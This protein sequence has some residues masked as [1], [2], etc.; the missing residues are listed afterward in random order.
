MEHVTR[1]YLDV[2]GAGCVEGAVAADSNC[3]AAVR[4]DGVC[5]V[6]CTPRCFSGSRW[7]EPGNVFDLARVE[8]CE[9]TQQRNVPCFSFLVAFC[10]WPRIRYLESLEKVGCRSASALLHLPASIGR[11]LVDGPTRVRA[12]KCQ[13]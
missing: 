10:T 3:D 5:S 7:R 12:G 1:R 2:I 13:R 11:L 6:R 8:Q 9:G 4:D